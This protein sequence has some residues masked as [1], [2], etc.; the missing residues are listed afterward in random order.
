MCLVGDNLLRSFFFAKYNTDVDANIYAHTLTPMNAHTTYLYE[1]LRETVSK[2]LHPRGLEIDEIT[3]G[4]SLSM[5]TSSPTEEY[6][7]FNDN[8]LR[9]GSQG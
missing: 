9:S 6:S 1:H 3:T 7:A 2:K 5:G 8:L 4:T